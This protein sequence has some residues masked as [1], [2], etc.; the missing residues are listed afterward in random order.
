LHPP[1]G[2]GYFGTVCVFPLVSKSGVNFANI[3]S[4]KGIDAKLMKFVRLRR[5]NGIGCTR[6]ID[7]DM[8]GISDSNFA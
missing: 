6:I 3:R 7:I 4:L 8:F 5:V 1:R 2:F